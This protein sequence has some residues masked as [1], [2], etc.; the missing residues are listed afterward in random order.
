VDVAERSSPVQRQ[1]EAYE[2]S[3]KQDHQGAM[4]CRDLEDT[5][6]V[7]I[8]VFRLIERVE[9]SWRERVFRGAE[10]YADPYDRWVQALYRGWLQVTDA[11][12]TAV[13]ALERRFGSVDGADELRACA[14]Q[15]RSLLDHWQPPRLSAAVGLREMTLTPEAAAELD[16]II[17]EAKK[18]PPSAPAGPVPEEMS[19]DDFF[20]LMRH[21]RP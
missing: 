16:R 10:N 15:A 3:W 1:L 19:A 8:A 17:D 13:P 20:A 7:G 4:A 9:D 12:L 18:V 11:V 21:P 6:A 2:E 14:G 5:V